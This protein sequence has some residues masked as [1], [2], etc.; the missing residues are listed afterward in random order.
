MKTRII[1]FIFALFGVNAFAQ[2]DTTKVWQRTGTGDSTDTQQDAI[3]NRPFITVGKS[4]TAVGG[5]LEG[6]TNYFVEDGITEG[7]SMELRR[8]NIFLYSTISS[9][10]RFLSELEFEHG[11]KEIALETALLDFRVNNSLNIRGGIILPQLGLFNANHDSPNWEF[12]ERPLSSTQI[13]PTTLSEV[14]FGVNGKFYLGNNIIGYDAYLI[15]GLQSGVVLNDQGRTFLEAGKSEEM[16]GEDNNG[17]PGFN[18]R[19]GLANRKWGE[20]G[21][22]YYTAVYNDFRVDGTTVADKNSLHIF[23]LDYNTSWGKLTAKGEY[24]YAFVEIPTELNGL[25]ASEQH[26]GFIDLIYPIIERQMAGYKNAKINL[27]TRLEYVDLNYGT[28]PETGAQIR[29]DIYSLAVGLSFRPTPT[30]IFRANYRYQWQTDFLGNP[31]V[32]T[33]GIQVGFAT[34]F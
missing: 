12:V 19:I 34:Y 22:S 2:Q 4:S 1:L 17:M 27:S 20:V 8:F 33:A 6:N 29:D 13:I 28:I 25:Y 21:A 23:A 16:F 3:Y 7:F 9:R 5:Y 18:G 15:N 30:T 10:I 24:V 11:T 14:G 32:N 26:G 31:A